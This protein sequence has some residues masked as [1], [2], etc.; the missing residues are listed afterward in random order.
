MTDNATYV[1]TTSP[2]IICKEV[3]TVELSREEQTALGS[4]ALIQHALPERSDGFRELVKTGTH[5]ECWDKMFMGF[6][7]D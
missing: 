2:C 4:G 7:E 5:P 3:S 6:D 1:I